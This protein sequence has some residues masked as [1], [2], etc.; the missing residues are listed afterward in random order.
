MKV[1]NIIIFCKNKEFPKNCPMIKD[2]APSCAKNCQ[3]I[4]HEKLRKKMEN[5]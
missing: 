3:W 4:N 2:N 5:K 1:R